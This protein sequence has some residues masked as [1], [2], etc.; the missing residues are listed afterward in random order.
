MRKLSKAAGDVDDRGSLSDGEVL[1]PKTWEKLYAR[2][3][4]PLPSQRGVELLR[5]SSEGLPMLV[6]SIGSL[7]IDLEDEEGGYGGTGRHIPLCPAEMC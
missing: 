6:G 3:D 4:I 5:S 7:P 2:M 1:A